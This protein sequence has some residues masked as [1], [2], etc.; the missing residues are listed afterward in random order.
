MDA[1]TKYQKQFESK[2]KNNSD[3]KVSKI[4]WGKISI[5]FVIV[6]LLLVGLVLGLYFGLRTTLPDV[7]VPKIKVDEALKKADDLKA[8]EHMGIVFTAKDSSAANYALYGEESPLDSSENIKDQKK[9]EGALGKFLLNYEDTQNAGFSNWY[10]VE[11]DTTQE[12]NDNIEKFLIADGYD[13]GRTDDYETNDPGPSPFTGATYIG[14]VQNNQTLE[15]YQKE[16]NTSYQ[17]KVNFDIVN[18][19]TDPT[20]LKIVTD[21]VVDDG[22]TETTTYSSRKSDDTIHSELPFDAPTIFWLEGVED[23]DGEGTH[24]E[25]SFFSI[26]NVVPSTS[27]SDSG[28]GDPL[29]TPAYDILNSEEAY[30][31]LGK[32][33]S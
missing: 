22:S 5:I 24:G 15:M 1:K 6:F 29:T 16:N 10:M 20:H 2:Q 8:G 14:N 18:D 4:N 9:A 33:L 25:L 28:T 30:K 13:F 32:K 26:G 27:T 19:S 7:G 12:T 11:S 31:L 21:L 3:K 23:S 17:E